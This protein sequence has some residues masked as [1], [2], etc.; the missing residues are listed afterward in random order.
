MYKTWLKL[1]TFL[2]SNHWH[3]LAFGERKQKIG[4]GERPV[5]RPFVLFILVHY[6]LPSGEPDEVLH[7][8]S[9]LTHQTAISCGPK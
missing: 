4:V 6:A 3:L 2:F 7:V 9:L 1:Y 8:V 5:Y